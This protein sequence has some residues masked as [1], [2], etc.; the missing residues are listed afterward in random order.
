MRRDNRGFS[1][2]ELL[3]AISVLSVMS[4]VL[5]RSFVLSRRFNAKARVDEIVLD[6]GE[7]TM[8]A[9]KGT[10]LTE[11]D[12]QMKNQ[13]PESESS[14][15]T[16]NGI[17]YT[18]V[19]TAQ[20][21]ASPASEEADA[22]AI[23]ADENDATDENEV[24]GTS[25]DSGNYKYV[26]TS[27]PQTLGGT[28]GNGSYV[29]EAEIRWSLYGD[30][31]AAAS[32]AVS[33]ASDDDSTEASG[34]VPDRSSVNTSQAPRIAD[35]SIPQNIVLDHE[36]LLSKEAAWWMYFDMLNESLITRDEEGKENDSACY[37]PEETG[38]VFY[39]KFLE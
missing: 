3:I 15:I 27:E 14:E 12:A 17:T 39:L 34:S 1:L 7:K 20:T 19:K 24:S 10:S 11:L 16:L 18:C 23:E 26:L 38:R 30:P 22:A 2:I 28:R 13:L 5:L 33:P 29:I 25:G 6:A 31:D 21:A 9:I 32:D 35:V 36:T 4:G 8:E 37:A